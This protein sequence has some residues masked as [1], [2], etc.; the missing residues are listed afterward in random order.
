[1]PTISFKPKKVTKRITSQLQDRASDVI[2]N[3]FG[4]TED[5]KIVPPKQQQQQAPAPTAAELRAAAQAE[6]N[7]DDNDPLLGPVVKAM[8][9]EL[10]KR[11]FI[12]TDLI[13]E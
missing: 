6:F 13:R 4:L 8:K 3:R 1:M 12:Y 5:G 7:L 11:G 9:S 2:M 10:A